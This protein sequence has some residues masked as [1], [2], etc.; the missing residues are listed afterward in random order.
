[1]GV[2]S[3]RG[4]ERTCQE[5]RD[6]VYFLRPSRRNLL[7]LRFW[8]LTDAVEKGFRGR[9]PSNIDSRLG[10]NAQ[11][12][13]ISLHGFFHFKIQFH[14]YFFGYFFNS[15]DPKRTPPV[16]F[17]VRTARS[18]YYRDNRCPPSPY[19]RSKSRCGGKERRRCLKPSHGGCRDPHRD[20][21]SLPS[22]S[23]RR[24]IRSRRLPSNR[25][26]RCL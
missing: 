12:R 19:S 1:M 3:A 10:T 20:I 21:R 24:H 22:T 11:F 26:D 5:V 15:I 4:T 25:C 18:K 13:F 8:L 23:G 9:S 14:N 6:D 17:N 16:I 7:S 2:M